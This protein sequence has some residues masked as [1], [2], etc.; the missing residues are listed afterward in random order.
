MTYDC[1]DYND[2]GSCQGCGAALGART[3]IGASYCWD[4][5]NG[6]NAEVAGGQIV[7]VPVRQAPHGR[8]LRNVSDDAA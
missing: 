3:G 5:R 7:E 4:C 8:T 2:A 1:P 6:A